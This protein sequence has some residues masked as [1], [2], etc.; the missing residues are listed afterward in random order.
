MTDIQWSCT[1]LQNAILYVGSSQYTLEPEPLQKY[2]FMGLSV[3]PPGV[4]VCWCGQY[5]IA[6]EGQFLQAQVPLAGQNI[7]VFVHSLS[8]EAWQ[9]TIKLSD[10]CP[11]ISESCNWSWPPPL[12]V[13]VHDGVVHVNR[14]FLQQRSPPEH[15]RDESATIRFLHPS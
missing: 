9:F 4:H 10:S 5:I 15:V 7:L 12:T 2:S 6:D 13:T 3:A 11:N 1:E 8:P 14:T